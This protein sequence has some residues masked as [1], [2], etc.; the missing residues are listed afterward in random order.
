MAKSF[1]SSHVDLGAK[2]T[3][4]CEPDPEGH[5]NFGV[6]VGKEALVV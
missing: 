5:L 3:V 6:R 1:R 2:F 4:S